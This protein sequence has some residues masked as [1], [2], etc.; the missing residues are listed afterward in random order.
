MTQFL[1]QENFPNHRLAPAHQHLL[2]SRVQSFYSLRPQ[3]QGDSLDEEAPYHEDS[4]VDVLGHGDL[5]PLDIEIFE[6]ETYRRPGRLWSDEDHRAWFQPPPVTEPFPSISFSLIGFLR[7]SGLSGTPSFVPARDL[8]PQR[9][10]NLLWE[11]IADLES[12]MEQRVRVMEA[13][14]VVLSCPR[15]MS[16]KAKRG[17]GV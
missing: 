5:T 3:G 7:D 17:R 13:Q 12:S 2:L 9:R 1:S 11:E 4:V 10:E 16:L 15:Q 8:C 6:A 14:R